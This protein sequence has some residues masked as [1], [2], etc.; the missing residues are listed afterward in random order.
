MSPALAGRFLT[1]APPGKSSLLFFIH[2]PS[3][4]KFSIVSNFMFSLTFTHWAMKR[5]EEEEE[6][7]EGEEEEGGGEEEEEEEEGEEG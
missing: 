6:E 2:W 1:T 3:L 4:C 7:E 5:V